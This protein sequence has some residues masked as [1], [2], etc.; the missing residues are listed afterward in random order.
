MLLAYH[1]VSR[2]MRRFDYLLWVEGQFSI[3]VGFE[4][5]WRPRSVFYS[6]FKDFICY[7]DVVCQVERLFMV[8]KAIGGNAHC[9]PCKC[10]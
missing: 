1:V 8:C 4:K 2:I 6:V 10:S 7:A 3:A 5:Y 9:I